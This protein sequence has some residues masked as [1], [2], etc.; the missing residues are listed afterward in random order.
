MSSRPAF[1]ISALTV[2]ESIDAPDAAEFIGFAAVRYAVIAELRGDTSPLPAP[3]VAA[4]ELLPNWRDEGNTS[5]GL[6][7]TVDG[8]VV[9]RGNVVLPADGAECWAA[10]AVLPEHRGAGIGSALYRGLERI[11]VDAGRRIIQ[12]QT[13]FPA[14]I[15]GDSL[16]APTGYGSVPLGLASTRFALR[17][18][19]SLEQVGRLSGFSLPGDSDL[20]AAHLSESSA[21]ASGYRTVTWQGR[22]P[23]DWVDAIALMRTRM[24][25]DTP[26][27]GIEMSDVWTAERVRAVDDLWEASPRTI[28]TTIAVHESTGEP[29]GFTELDVPAEHDRPVEQMDTLVL[30]G[31]RGRRLGMLLKLTNLRELSARFPHSAEV[32]TMNAEDNRHML[33]VNEAVGFR[34]LAYSARWKKVVG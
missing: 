33:D 16:P 5:L 9:G 6:V 20:M 3:E 17:F 1:T 15:G 7:A 30:A 27:A 31:H 21:A 10:V 18:G 22:T 23:E 29:A 34:P 4:A 13:D 28:L 19:F 8:R 32:Q 25:T 2:P 14:G 24:S 12:N 11:A 26:N